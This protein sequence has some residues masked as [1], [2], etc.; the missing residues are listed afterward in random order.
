[1]WQDHQDGKYTFGSPVD[2]LF[3][4]ALA[5][6]YIAWLNSEALELGGPFVEPLPAEARE[7]WAY[8]THAHW[9]NGFVTHEDYTR[10]D[11][12]PASEWPK[13]GSW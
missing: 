10:F 11:D 2:L 5:R 3:A 1:M 8:F 4:E 6:R 7:I 12:L 9:K 13:P